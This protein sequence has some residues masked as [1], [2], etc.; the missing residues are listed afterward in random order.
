MRISS[1]QWKINFKLRI[2]LNHNIYN[3]GHNC[4]YTSFCIV[5]VLKLIINVVARGEIKE[6]LI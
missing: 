5:T 4:Q 6:I 1:K 3:A 2:K